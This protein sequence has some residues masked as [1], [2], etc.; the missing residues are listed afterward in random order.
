[1]AII[2]KNKRREDA[3]LNIAQ[4]TKIHSDFYYVKFSD[5]VYEC[6]IRE[7][8]KKSNKEIFIGDF[9]KFEITDEKSLTGIIFDIEKRKNFIPR[10]AVANL[11]QIIIISAIKEPDFDY[12]QLDRY[13]AFANLNNINA[14]ICINKTD[15][16]SD[17]QKLSDIKNL[18]ES[19]NY[20][21]IDVSA[22]TKDNLD[23]LKNILKNKFSVFCGQSGVGKS[24][25]LNAISPNLHLRVKSVSTKTTRGTHTTRHSEI[26]EINLGAEKASI[27]DTPGFS[28]LKFDCILPQN[29]TNLF[30]D[31][32]EFSSYCRYN[33]CLHLEEDGCH[34][35]NNLEKIAPSRYKSYKNFVEEALKYKEK[36][37]KEGNKKETTTKTIDKSQKKIEIAKLGIKKREK[38]RRFNKQNLVYEHM[39]DEE[40][41]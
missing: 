2:I 7:I 16:S 12:T 8:L 26:L 31:I 27:A 36:L 38:S 17:H 25:L 30:P 35:K 5:K 20:K 15:L 28:L 6:K 11:D 32:L 1:M 14:I 9:V 22:K 37:S 29:I 23:S 18:Y 24:S 19:L 33:N 39:E 34:V 10:P 41:E 21:I 13:L 40:H 4:V 3:L